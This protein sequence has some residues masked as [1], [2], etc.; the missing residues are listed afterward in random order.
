MHWRKTVLF[1]KAFFLTNKKP[2]T[3]NEIVKAVAF[4]NNCNVH[5]ES[6]SREHSALYRQLNISTCS[7]RYLIHFYLKPNDPL[8]S[9][10]VSDAG[11]SSTPHLY[12]A[13]RAY[14]TSPDT[15]IHHFLAEIC[16]NS[17]RAVPPTRRRTN[18]T[19]NEAVKIQY[20]LL[21]YFRRNTN[22]DMM[23]FPAKGTERFPRQN[24]TYSR[25]L[26]GTSQNLL[27]LTFLDSFHSSREGFLLCDSMISTRKCLYYLIILLIAGIIHIK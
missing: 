7:A 24:L 18:S 22:A 16:E 5:A 2:L 3:Y 12:Y 6:G 15:C 8:P 17:P 20:C 10:P 21:E 14:V 26:V 27:A 11:P 19:K 25:Y 9:V 13:R 23:K 4:A 1:D